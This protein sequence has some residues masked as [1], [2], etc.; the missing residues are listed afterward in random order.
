MKKSSKNLYYLLIFALLGTFNSNKLYASPYSEAYD[1]LDMTSNI[2]E[3]VC[4][5]GEP[6]RIR[7]WGT[8]PDTRFIYFKGAF[9]DRV[10]KDV[11]PYVVYSLNKP[12]D[13]I[14]I[15]KSLVTINEPPAKRDD[16][17]NELG[18]YKLPVLRGVPHE[19]SQ[20]TKQLGQW[21]YSYIYKKIGNKRIVYEKTMCI[22]KKLTYGAYFDIRNGKITRAK[23]ITSIK[24]LN[25]HRKRANKQP[26]Q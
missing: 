10:R 15:S 3:A 14:A 12:Q 24:S 5:L 7:G 26:V 2:F 19:L 16:K 13:S 8:D 22:S 17:S 1:F 20:L 25:K 23:G 21:N 11:Y 9:K 6:I 18:R 4:L